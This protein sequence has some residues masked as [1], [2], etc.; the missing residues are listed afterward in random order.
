MRKFALVIA[1]ALLAIIIAP[2]LAA[3][4]DGQTACYGGDEI[5]DGRTVYFDGERPGCVDGIGIRV[6]VPNPDG[7]FVT[8]PWLYWGAP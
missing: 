8:G 3:Y 7:V 5:L 6:A 2:V 4:T 1:I